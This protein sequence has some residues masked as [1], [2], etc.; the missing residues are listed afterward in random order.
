MHQATVQL[1]CGINLLRERR[2]QI[3]ENV[4][5]SFIFAACL[6][7]NLTGK[8]SE[9]GHD[10]TGVSDGKRPSKNNPGVFAG[11]LV[12]AEKGRLDIVSNANPPL[13]TIISAL[14][15]EVAEVVNN[16]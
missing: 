7:N 15:N 5:R 6:R 13:G 9:R 2:D 12:V 1:T 14:L 8:I 11:Q 10:G 3:G 4:N 16:F